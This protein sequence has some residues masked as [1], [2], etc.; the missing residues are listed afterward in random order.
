MRSC[1]RCAAAQGDFDPGD[2]PLLKDVAEHR[3]RFLDAMDDDFNTGGAIGDL[4][5]LVRRLNK[6]IDDEKLEEPGSRR[7]RP[8]S[9]RSAAARPCSARLGATLGLFRQPP[10]REAAGGDDELVGK[11]MGCLIE[12]RAEARKKKD[13]ATADQIR[14]RLAEIGVDAGRPSRRHGVEPENEFGSRKSEVGR[15]DGED[16]PSRVRLLPSEFR[17]PQFRILGIDPG[18]NITGYGVLE[19]GGG[20]PRLCEAGVVRGKSRGSLTGRLLEIH[21]GVADVIAALRP[22]VM[23][24]EQLYSH[25]AAAADGDPHGP[26]PRRDLPGRRRGRHPRRPLRGH[27]GQEGSSPAPAGPARRR[28]SGRSSGN[29]ASPQLPEPPD[30]ADALAV[31]LCHCYLEGSAPRQLQ[32]VAEPSA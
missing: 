27:A 2:D 23:A 11:L 16:R 8:S 32:T 4:F 12:L 1:R 17:L 20:P 13:F 3:N 10:A 30:V 6:Y 19:C 29:C 24:L 28:C 21:Q 26:R 31:A 15:D 25:Y 18:L 5:E 7:R 22:G 14:K 9:P